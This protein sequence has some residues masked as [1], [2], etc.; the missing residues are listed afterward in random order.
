MNRKQA[1]AE[2]V[3]R[4][5]KDAMIQDRPRCASS[6]EE[7]EVARKQRKYLRDTLTKE[8]LKKRH[9]DMDELLFDSMRYR[10]SV[11]IFGGF[12]F[13]VRGSGDTWEEAFEAADRMWGKAA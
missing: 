12:F 4:W 10:F 8:D 7:R 11:G 3:K 5:G 13:G 9:K 1:L 2:A 6:P